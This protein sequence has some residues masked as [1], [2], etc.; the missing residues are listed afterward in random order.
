MLQGKSAVVTG[1]TS[2]IGLAIAEGLAQAGANV[3]LNGS[4]DGSAVEDVRQKLA[5]ET[6]V[7]VIYQQ[8]DMT[9]PTEI[10]AMMQRAEDAFGGTDIL[11]NNA[12]IQFVSPIEDFPVEKWDQIMAINLFIRLSHHP[13]G[14]AGHEGPQMGAHSEYR[15]GPIR[16]WH[17][18]SNPPMSPPSTAF[19]A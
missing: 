16:W 9:K 12:G 15:I 2:G 17:P 5:D 19:W 8:A 13:A 6:G 14:R 3:L 10:E 4:R 11:I 7:Q 1:S 18:R